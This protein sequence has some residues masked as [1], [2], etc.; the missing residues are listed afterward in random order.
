MLLSIEMFL[1]L[2]RRTLRKGSAFPALTKIES[3]EAAPRTIRAHVQKAFLFAAIL[4]VLAPVTRAQESSS[5][6]QSP[7]ATDQI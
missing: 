2:C 4:F 6:T 3:C 7:V 5:P 1:R